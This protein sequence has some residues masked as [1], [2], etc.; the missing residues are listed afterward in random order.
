MSQHCGRV[1]HRGPGYG[2]EACALYSAS[3]RNCGTH[4][5]AS[6]PGGGLWVTLGGG[7][8]CSL[9]HQCPV[10]TI[11]LLTEARGHRTARRWDSVPLSEGVFLAPD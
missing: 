6:R 5:S 10:L 3:P 7:Q 11:I 1:V 8:A 2:V 9:V 4:L